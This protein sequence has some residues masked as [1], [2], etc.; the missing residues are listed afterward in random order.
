MTKWRQRVESK[1]L[2]EL[3][4]A[5]IKAGMKMG[6]IRKTDFEHV[7][8]DT[9]VSE[10]NISFP[11]DAKLTYKMIFKLGKHAKSH[12]IKLRQS[13]VR[14]GAMSYIMQSRFRRANQHKKANREIMKL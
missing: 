13:F 3:L 1:N 2:D 10:K 8:V 11:T 5:T 12:G 14:V 6:A 4:S 7:N 9:T